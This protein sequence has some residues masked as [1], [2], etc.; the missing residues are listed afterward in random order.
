MKNG[1][2]VRHLSFIAAFI[3]VSF[4]AWLGWSITSLGNTNSFS[5][6]RVLGS[7]TEQKN[8]ERTRV[9]SVIDGDTFI[10]EDGRKVRLI[11]IDAPAQGKPYY[12]EAKWELMK[13]ILHKEV[14]LL[15]DKS[16]G[17]KEGRLLRYVY[18]DDTLV[19]EK[20]LKSG[21]AKV[22]TLPPDVAQS[23]LFLSAERAAREKHVGMWN[24]R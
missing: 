1:S 19:N 11:G 10:L 16:E 14:S 12:D 3:V 4:M 24:D 23:Q 17:D 6:S 2:D 15:K 20:M 8:G 13:L 18:V 5:F 7:N 21:L 22:L 9:L